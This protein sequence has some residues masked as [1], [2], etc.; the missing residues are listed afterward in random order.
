MNPFHIA[1]DARGRR[2]GLCICP[3][4]ASLGAFSI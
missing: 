2:S 4:D 3:G 1:S